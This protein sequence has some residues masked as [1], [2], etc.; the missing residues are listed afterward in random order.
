MTNKPP[1]ERELQTWHERWEQ[2]ISDLENVWLTRSTY[3]G[4]DHLTIADLLGKMTLIKNHIDNI[5]I[6]C[7]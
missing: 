3:L 5:I 2:S 4:G 7:I 1:N 6:I